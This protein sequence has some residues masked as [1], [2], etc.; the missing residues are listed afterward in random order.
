MAQN[1]YRAPGADLRKA[2]KP[3]TSAVKALLIGA[4]ID[5][6]GSFGMGV[7]LAIGYAVLA[8]GRGMTAD[9]IAAEMAHIP[10]DSRFAL[11]GYGLGAVI[12]V[13]AGFVCARLSRRTDYRL[14]WILAAFS[15]AA[16]IVFA[17]STAPLAVNIMIALLG[18]CAILL[19]TR[20]G[21]PARPAS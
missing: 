8:A 21:M 14:G 7:V 10:Y 17:P 20:L 3:P 6:G 12:S 5:I 11:F 15:V 1:P 16:G 13:L 9:Q 4:A 19:G 18:A 2:P